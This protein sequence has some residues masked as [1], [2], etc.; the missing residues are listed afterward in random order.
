[1][2][3]GAPGRAP[4]ARG[5]ARLQDVA[6]LA[7]VSLTTASHALSGKRPVS[8]ATRAVVLRTAFDLGFVGHTELTTQTFGLLLRPPESLPAF[9]AGTE[10]FARLMG[11]VTMAMLSR[12]H[13]V[14]SFNDLDEVGAQI[15][16]VHAFA[17]LH[18]NRNDAVLRDVVARG[19]PVVTYDPDLGVPEHRWWVGSNYYGSCRRLIR[20]LLDRG[21]RRIALLAGQT[22]NMYMTEILRAYADEV[23][24]QAI[25]P[26]VCRASAA[27][28]QEAGRKAAHAI[29][30]STK[31]VDAV[32]TSS[33]TFALGVL[34][35]AEAIGLRVPADLH[36]ATMTDGPLPEFARVPITA[37]RVDSLAAAEQLVSLL[38][39]RCG[40][41]DAPKR[42]RSLNMNLIQRMSTQRRTISTTHTE[43]NP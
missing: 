19:L 25:D 27:K 32:I 6:T 31:H 43:D 7:G 16:R 42:G 4:D 20:H 2:I 37:M 11:A 30:S 14:V 36:L 28:G 9:A 1:M 29:F 38:E 23:A 39:S 40:G 3:T 17:L 8:P 24:A 13:N 41:A 34:A 5:T 21:S 35:E 26:V 22:D 10:S 12:G 33:G 18:P 15:G